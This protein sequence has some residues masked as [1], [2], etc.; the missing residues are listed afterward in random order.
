MTDAVT[1]GSGLVA[2]AIRLVYRSAALPPV[3]SP[4]VAPSVLAAVAVSA[5]QVRMNWVDNA[6]DETGFKIEQGTNATVF[7]AIATVS[8]NVIS[9]AATGLTAGVTYFFR[10]KSFNSAGDSAYANVA[11]AA[12]PV[13]LLPPAAPTGFTGASV[14]SNKNALAWQ[15]NAGNEDGF[16]IERSLNGSAFAV[17]ATVGANITAY[18]HAGVTPGSTNTYRVLAFNAAGNSAYSPTSVVVA[19]E[20]IFD[21][22]GPALDVTTNQDAWVTHLDPAGQHYKGSHR[23][24]LNPGNGGDSARWTFYVPSEAMYDIYA[25]WWDGA[26]RSPDVPYTVVYLG[27]GRVTVKVDQR[28][29]G[30]Q[31]NLLGTFPLGGTNSVSVSDAVTGGAGIVADAIRLVIRPDVSVTRPVP[32]TG[33]RVTP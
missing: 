17:L 20:F 28:V 16:R 3:K 8:S 21:D 2:D 14:E 10:V 9:Y 30:G 33:I 6:A 15:D 7:S 22:A 13:L 5:S 23:Y 27:G 18:T 29:N 24:N 31:W 4:P 25:W 32:P 1:S 26:T 11:S 19:G 12:T